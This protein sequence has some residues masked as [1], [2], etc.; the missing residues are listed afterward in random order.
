M[1]SL[2]VLAAFAVVAGAGAQTFFTSARASS[3]STR[4]LDTNLNSMFNASPFAGSSGVNVAVGDLNGDFMPDYVAGAASGGP[5]VVVFDGANRRPI[6]DF[7]AFASFTGGVNVAMG[8]VNN[9]GT[10]DILVGGEGMNCPV[11]VYSG[12]NLSILHSFLAY[13]AFAGG[14][15]VAAGDVNGDGADD[16]IIAP[17]PGRGPRIQV[18]N[19]LTGATL[20]DFLAYD[21]TFTGGVFVAAGDVNGDGVDDLVTGAGLGGGP[22][23]R[24]FDGTTLNSLA[25]FL[26][27]DPAFTGGVHVAAGDVNGDAK[28][29]LVVGQSS[30][31]GTVR[32]FATPSLG[33]TN[34]FQPEGSAFTGGIA[35]GAADRPST[36]DFGFYLNKDT[37]AGQNSVL[38]SVFTNVP[39]MAATTFTT[40]DNTSLVVTPSTAI[41]ANGASFKNFQLT[42][43]AINSTINVTISAKL[44]PKTLVRPLTLA[45]LVPTSISFNPNPVNGGN[46][47]QGRVVI[48][49]VAGPNGRTISIVENSAFVT[50]PTS[51]TVPPGGT[52]VFFTITTSAVSSNQSVPFK[53]IVSAGLCSGTLRLTP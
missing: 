36:F 48:N 34:T 25:D 17:G 44:G 33:L 41:V 28:A 45:P 12:T 24:V 22:R 20:R 50:S 40:F 52:D 51:V 15:R 39:V 16:V 27:F 30:M 47:T 43:T 2:S 7:N 32:V 13:P 29:D 35:V 42:T 38:A 19:G 9:D 3:N 46:T 5:H 26:A 37:V 10:D 18:F 8:D 4:L 49:G 21:E 6:F 23:V 11:N 14:V 1:R 53:A 31:G